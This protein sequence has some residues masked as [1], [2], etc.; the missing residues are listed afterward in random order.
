[1]LLSGTDFQ[2]L[3]GKAWEELKGWLEP[4]SVPPVGSW[5]HNQRFQEYL[6]TLRKLEQSFDLQGMKEDATKVELYRRK[7][8]SSEGT[9]GTKFIYYFMSLTC[10]YGHSLWRLPVWWLACVCVFA[11]AFR[12]TLAR[13]RRKIRHL[14]P[15]GEDLW[16]SLQVFLNVS[17]PTVLFEYKAH[18][19]NVHLIARLEQIV[20]FL[21][22]VVTTI[23][24][25]IFWAR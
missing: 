14:I 18:Q 6:N 8:E 24:L 16:K 12:I 1:M 21:S 15:R 9:I 23:L 10:S 25:G 2:I 4:K 7:L 5:V 3:E 22:V 19:K 20:G 17:D 13:Q 11:T